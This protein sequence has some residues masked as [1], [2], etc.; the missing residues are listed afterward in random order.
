MVIGCTAFA[1]NGQ[2][3]EE[4]VAVVGNNIILKSELEAEYQTA[5]AQT[6]FFD[7]DLKSEVLNQLIIQKLYYHKGIMDTIEVA[8]EMVQD[9]VERRVQ[10]YIMQAGGERNFE[11][12]LK[13]SIDEFKEEMMPRVKEQMIVNQVQRELI[14]EVSVSPSDVQAFF[15]KIPQDSLPIFDREVELAQLV[16]SPKP[17][18]F[19]VRY[20]RE[21]A[22]RIR[23]NIIDG[24]YSFEDAARIKSD[25][26]GSAVNGGE[27]GYFGR[28]KMVGEFERVAFT[29]TKDSISELVETEFGFHIIQLIDRKGEQ[30]NARH[31]LIRPQVLKA[32]IQKLY[33]E[34]KD[35]V[36]QLRKDSISFCSAVQKYSVDQ[37]TKENCGFFSDPN[38]GSNSISVDLLDQE[39]LRPLIDLTAGEYSDPIPFINYDGSQSYKILYLKASKPKHRANLSDDYQKIQ[40][41]ALEEAQ[42]KYV[43]DW[44]QD[45]KKNVYIRIDEKYRNTKELSSW[46]GLD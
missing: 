41:M 19:A 32:D 15:A 18:E 33:L 8:D 31:I 17:S 2:V 20:A 37:Y 10:Y 30:V 11:I 27:L 43:E 9:E 16:M 38:T 40:K 7:G 12:F 4:V 1:Q 24:I 22:A 14:A 29:L 46:K 21:E 25:D 13:K 5:L 34:M 26:K 45:Y 6:S 3:L 28:G 36:R 23:E 39:T 42:N 35:L 44:I